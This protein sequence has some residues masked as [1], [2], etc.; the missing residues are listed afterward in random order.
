M[1]AILQNV[2]LQYFL[3]EDWNSIEERIIKYTGM[4]IQSEPGGTT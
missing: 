4:N 2:K 3:L 1:I